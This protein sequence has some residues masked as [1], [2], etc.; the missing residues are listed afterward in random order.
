MSNPKSAIVGEQ[1][2]LQTPIP[3]DDDTQEVQ[4]KDASVE[5][6]VADLAEHP[7]WKFIRGEF[8]KQIERYEDVSAVQAQGES[9]EKIAQQVRVNLQVVRILSGILSEV[10]THVG[11]K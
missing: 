6:Q 2:N 9:D 4:D 3:T 7:G 5:K 10:D 11:S 1:V 8:E